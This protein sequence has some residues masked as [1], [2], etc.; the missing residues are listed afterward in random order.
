MVTGA[1]PSLGAE[2]VALM[3]RAS[4]D[5]RWQLLSIVFPY[6]VRADH[7]GEGGWKIPA[8]EAQ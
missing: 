7:P 5:V 1:S 8:K 3:V 2:S 6:P 4:A